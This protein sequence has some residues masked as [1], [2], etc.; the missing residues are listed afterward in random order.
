MA[1][2]NNGDAFSFCLSL[3]H[4]ILSCCI[5][6]LFPS[7]VMRKKRQKDPKDTTYIRK[8]FGKYQ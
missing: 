6:L 2:P 8:K 4:Q 7:I 3:C 1:K 5:L